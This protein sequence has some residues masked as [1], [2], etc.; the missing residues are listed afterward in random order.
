MSS[1]AFIYSQ[2]ELLFIYVMNRGQCADQLN[3][4][5]RSS[6]RTLSLLHK[7]MK[8]ICHAHVQ[9]ALYYTVQFII[10]F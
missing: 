8:Q 4:F 10:F 6:S 5:T 9:Y 1:L 7:T 2:L 3:N